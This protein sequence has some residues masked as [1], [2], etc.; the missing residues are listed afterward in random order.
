MVAPIAIRQPT[1]VPGDSSQAAPRRAPPRHPRSATGA[2]P[3]PRR[4]DGSHRTRRRA[5]EARCTAPAARAPGSAPASAGTRAAGTPASDRL[6][7]ARLY[8]FPESWSRS[9]MV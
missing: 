8:R 6:A 7:P 9:Q 3:A 5:P 1:V 4:L 2:A